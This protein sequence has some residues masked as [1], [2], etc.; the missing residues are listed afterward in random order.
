MH[1]NLSPAFMDSMGSLA[2][3]YAVVAGALTVL[4]HL[5]F[6]A[7]V[8]MDTAACKLVPKPIWVC[9]TLPTGPLAGSFY[10]IIHHGVPGITTPSATPPYIPSA[11]A[12][13]STGASYFSS[14]PPP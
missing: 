6:T 10:W 14:N 1:L 11:P 5:F 8:A 2:T 13:P 9:E 3:C 12:A 4:V 7:G